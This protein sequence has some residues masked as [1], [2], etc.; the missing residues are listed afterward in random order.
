MSTVKEV[1][2]FAKKSTSNSRVDESVE[3]RI[4]DCSY[5]CV[6]SKVTWHCE[7]G[8]LTLRGCVPSFY[9]KQ[10]LQEAIRGIDGIDQICNEVDVVNSTG[11]S[12]EPQGKPRSK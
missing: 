5:R 1:K 3:R 4:A 7:A 8:R 2:P 9:L 6:F 10:V 12:S 11:L